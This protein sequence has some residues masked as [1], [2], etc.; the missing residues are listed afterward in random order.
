MKHS[1]DEKTS[2]YASNAYSLRTA[3]SLEVIWAN[4][5]LYAQSCSEVNR[6]EMPEDPPFVIASTVWTGWAGAP[7]ERPDEQQATGT[8]RF[9]GAA[10]GIASVLIVCCIVQMYC[11]RPVVVV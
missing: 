3:L 6:P 1:T 7:K 8:M 9:L 11:D 4:L 2:S 5:S 10:R